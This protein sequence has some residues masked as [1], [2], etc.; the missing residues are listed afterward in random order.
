MRLKP[1]PILSRITGSHLEKDRLLSQPLILSRLVAVG[2]LGSLKT[3]KT[4]L[5]LG[6]ARS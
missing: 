5:S 6:S 3:V 4:G 1:D 2:L